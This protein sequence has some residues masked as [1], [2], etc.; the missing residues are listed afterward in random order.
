MGYLTYGR[1]PADLI[2]IDRLLMVVVFEKKVRGRM[3]IRLAGYEVSRIEHGVQWGGAKNCKLEKDLALCPK[4]GG[5]GLRLDTN[6]Q[7]LFQLALR[8]HKRLCRVRKFARRTAFREPRLPRL[9]AGY[10]EADARRLEGDGPELAALAERFDLPQQTLLRKFE[11]TYDG[12]VVFPLDF[13]SGNLDSAVTVFADLES[14]PRVHVF[15]T[16]QL[17]NGLHGFQGATAWDFFESSIRFRSVC[18]TSKAIPAR[19]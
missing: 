18:S 13:V 4:P 19:S 9:W 10:R 16:R 6:R 2:E 3:F 17:S 7:E 11:R 5:R 15:R 8:L 1:Q 12:L 14:Y